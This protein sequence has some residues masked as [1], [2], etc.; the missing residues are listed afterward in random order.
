M[1]ETDAA[2]GRRT[3][4]RCQKEEKKRFRPSRIKI[5]YFVIFFLTVALRLPYACVK[6]S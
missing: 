4:G 2:W 1:V 3:P 5:H 6:F